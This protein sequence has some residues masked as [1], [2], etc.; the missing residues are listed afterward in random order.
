VDHV[1]DVVQLA[2]GPGHVKAGWSRGG[3]TKEA[4]HRVTHASPVRR[5]GFDVDVFGVVIV[6]AV[7]D[8]GGTSQ[9][10]LD[11]MARAMCTDFS[12]TAAESTSSPAA[13]AASK[14]IRIPPSLLLLLLLLLARRSAVGSARTMSSTRSAHI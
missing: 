5:D 6:S 3:G 1:Q 8:N 12:R 7:F 10:V 9:H 13:A 11:Q 4:V 2:D 14:G